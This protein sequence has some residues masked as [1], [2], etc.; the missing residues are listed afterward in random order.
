MAFPAVVNTASSVEATDTTTH[1]VPLPSG[2]G[3]WLLLVAAINSATAGTTTR[4]TTTGTTTGTRTTGTTTGTSTTGTMGTTTGTT[5]ASRGTT[6][7][8]TTGA[9]NGASTTGS[10]TNGDG[11]SS[12][13]D[14]IRDT[15]P[16]GR[17]LPNT[18]C[19]SVL[20]PVAALLALLINGAA[21]GLMFMRRR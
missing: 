6:T 12:K 10:Q 8:D 13:K 11:T 16:E 4:S 9:T 18:G 21:I 3:G 5:D 7:G 1:D 20:V 14:V 15:I 19:L 17:E 2:S